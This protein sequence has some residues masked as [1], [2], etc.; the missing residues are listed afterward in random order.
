MAA[1]YLILLNNF[2]GFFFLCSL[3]VLLVTAASLP[4]QQTQKMPGVKV[5]AKEEFPGPG[6]FRNHSH[7]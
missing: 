7:L 4:F 6:V 5:V 2:K 1:I 3:S